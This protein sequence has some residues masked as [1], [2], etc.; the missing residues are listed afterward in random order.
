MSDIET[1]RIFR[2]KVTSHYSHVSPFSPDDVRKMLIF[3]DRGLSGILRVVY[4]NVIEQVDSR[5]N[6]H[7]VRF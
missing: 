5:H 7:H 2:N 4:S 3:A 6:S 1:R